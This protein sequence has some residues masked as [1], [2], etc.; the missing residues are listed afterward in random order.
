MTGVRPGELENGVIEDNILI[1][2]D[3]GDDGEEWRPKTLSSYRRV[4]LPPGFSR[5]TTSPKTWRTNLRKIITD[6]AVTPHSGRH[7]FIEVSRRAGCDSQIV[8]EICGHG[9]DIG[10]SSQRGYGRFT[11]EVL[12]RETQKIWS[13]INNNI[14]ET[15]HEKTRTRTC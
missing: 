3:T 9:S 2:Q 7:F 12:I 13:Y 6:K 11:D 10:S 5:P 4:P 15:T 8:A 14:L 1:V